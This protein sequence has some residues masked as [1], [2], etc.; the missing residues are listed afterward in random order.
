MHAW[1]KLPEQTTEYNMNP[2]NYELWILPLGGRCKIGMNLCVF[3][4]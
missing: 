1:H 3:G 2:N 4:A